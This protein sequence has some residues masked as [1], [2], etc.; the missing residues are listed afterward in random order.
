M[1]IKEICPVWKYYNNASYIFAQKDIKE[2]IRNIVESELIRNSSTVLFLK[3]STVGLNYLFFLF[4]SN[5]YGAK[6]VGIFSVSFTLLQ[7]FS[8][9]SRS[10]LE[11]GI[12]K[13]IS[14]QK[15]SKEAVRKY[16]S[17][18]R[19]FILIISILLL[20]F[21]YLIDLFAP[22]L[23]F[24]DSESKKYLG[25]FLLALPF[26]A[27]M[28]FNSE[29]FRASSKFIRFMFYQNLGMYLMLCLI[30]GFALFLFELNFELLAIYFTA[31]LVSLCLSS[32]FPSYSHQYKGEENQSAFKELLSQ[33]IP[34]GISTLSFF[35]MNWIDGIVIAQFYPE[36]IAGKYAIAFRIALLGSFA[37]MAVNSAIGPKVS[38]L[39]NSNKIAEMMSEARKSTK[40]G[41]YISVP[42]MLITFIFPEFLLSIFGEEFTDAV[43]PLLILLVGQFFN[44]ICGPTGVVL[45]LTGYQKVFRNIVLVSAAINILLN[46]MIIPHYG[47]LGAA[48]VNSFS[49]IFWNIW[50][51]IKIQNIFGSGFYYI[52][53]FRK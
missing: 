47:I 36:E 15:K 7:L 46:Y 24:Q 19:S 25:I 16:L 26:Y 52:P 50:A 31:S 3:L 11:I 48:C 22:N 41:F 14:S 30:L 33:S 39:Y 43:L 23:I 9:L 5:Y 18:S 13:L 37:L 44:T 12:F 45:Q 34:I 8:I 4:L 38:Q 29:V 40:L 28:F 49:I 32:F 6:E 42:V 53:F 17:R 20:A 27:L 2:R 21:S 35:I 10:G 51:S 1:A